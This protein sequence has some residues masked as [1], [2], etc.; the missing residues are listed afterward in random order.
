MTR[1][2]SM[3]KRAEQQAETR[4]RI[5]EAAIDLHGTVGPALTTFSM[6]AEKA[7]VQRHTLYAHFPDERSL[8]MACS[9]LHLERNPLP[10][11][12]PW[13][14]I[15]DPDQR[16]RTGLSALYGWFEANAGIAGCVMR[17]AEV[18]EVTREIAAL[19]MGPHMAA[20]REVLGQGLNEAQ[21]AL[22][23]LALDF[24]CWRSLARD[25]GINAGHA[26]E[27]MARAIACVG[28]EARIPPSR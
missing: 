25:S 17:D 26:A 24:H 15:N 20:Y 21:S 10:E 5:V 6:V 23:S 9:G 3:K 16:L 1:N 7:G 18:H 12:E 13:G 19:R 11:A 2:Y 8:Q 4:L 22:L 28:S 27:L 14:L